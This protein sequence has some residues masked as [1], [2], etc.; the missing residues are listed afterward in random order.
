MDDRQAVD[1][2]DAAVEDVDATA[3]QIAALQ[4]DTAVVVALGT[5][6]TMSGTPIDKARDAIGGLVRTLDT[7]TEVAI[8]TFG[9]EPALLQDFT[10]DS[11]ALLSALNRIETGKHTPSV[12][13]IEKIDAALQ[14]ATQ[15]K[16]QRRK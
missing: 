5:G 1:V 8:V 4:P 14:A 3:A 13:T 12:A 9:D 11:R 6:D 15:P 7:G 16:R 10:T 2:G